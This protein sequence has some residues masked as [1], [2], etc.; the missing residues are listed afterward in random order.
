M[1]DD[2]ITIKSFDGGTFAAYLAKPASGQGP[3]L[4][5]LQEIFGVNQVMRDIADW[6]AAR[7]FTV[8]CPDLFW[9]QEPN[10]QLTDKSAADW[11][12]AFALYQG[13]DEAKAVEDAA[14]ALAA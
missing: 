12:R 3:G 13:L 5:L 1:R 14:A 10:I 8:I 4:V 7:G 11:Q 2:M 6:Y 9:R